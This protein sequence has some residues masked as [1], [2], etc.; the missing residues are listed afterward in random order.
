MLSREFDDLLIFF[1]KQLPPVRSI[2]AGPLASSIYGPINFPISMEIVFNLPEDHTEQKDSNRQL[3]AHPASRSGARSTRNRHTEIG[4]HMRRGSLFLVGPD[5]LGR[6]LPTLLPC[7]L[8]IFLQGCGCGAHPRR[9]RPA[10][11]SPLSTYLPASAPI[12]NCNY[13]KIFQLYNS[14]HAIHR[15]K[16]NGRAGAGGTD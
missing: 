1:L 12:R 7:Y 15:S 9:P 8:C 5:V 2:V 16:G 4:V 14:Y 13:A 10:A 11:V 3:N 6:C